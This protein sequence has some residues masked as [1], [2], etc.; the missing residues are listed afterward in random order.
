MIKSIFLSLFAISV[1]QPLLAQIDAG[2]FRFPDV[3][4]T[5]I[6]FTYANDLWLVPKDGG[7]A[8]KLSIFR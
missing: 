6:V 4:K 2:L 3:S 8:I 7:T 1:F 5:H